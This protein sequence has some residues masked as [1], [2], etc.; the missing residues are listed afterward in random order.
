MKKKKQYDAV[1]EVR[2]VRRKLSKLYRSNPI[3]FTQKL[4]AAS[5]NFYS[6]FKPA[7]S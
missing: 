3:L 5:E 6:Y 1:A 7:Q 4:Q 2:K